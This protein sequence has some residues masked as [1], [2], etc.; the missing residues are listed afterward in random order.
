MSCDKQLRTY[1]PFAG[2]ALSR[3]RGF[4]QA[5]CQL[6]KRRRAGLESNPPR[7]GQ[8]E[9]Q[10]NDRFPHASESS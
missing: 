6:V 8:P 2:I 10:R 9:T 5:G 7:I 1:M 4:V 3:E